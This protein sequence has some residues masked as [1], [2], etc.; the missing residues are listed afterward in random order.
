MRKLAL[1]H[2]ILALIVVACGGNDEKTEEPEAVAGVAGDVSNGEELYKQTLIGSQPGCITCHSLE[3]DQVIV[4]PSMAGVAGRAGTRVS[5]KS[6]EEYLR[7]SILNP[8]A[9]TVEGFG[10]GVMPGA[11]GD[12][13]S[14]QQLDDLVAYLLTLK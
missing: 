4:G 12:E 14:D 2:L 6:A 11:L 10:A 7:E 3:P 13:F 1:I 5:G 8:D 9:Y